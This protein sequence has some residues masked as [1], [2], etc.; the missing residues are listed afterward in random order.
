METLTGFPIL[1]SN[2]NVNSFSLNETARA[3]GRSRRSLDR[4][5]KRGVLPT[6]QIGWQVRISRQTL[7]DILTGKLK[8]GT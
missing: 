2:P 8:Y 4:D 6:I 1:D 3:L 7:A 5:I